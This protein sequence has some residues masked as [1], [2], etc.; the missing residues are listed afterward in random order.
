MERSFHFGPDVLLKGFAQ[1]QLPVLSLCSAI[2]SVV[3]CSL[4][5]DSVF[6]SNCFASES[7][8]L[9]KSSKTKCGPQIF[10]SE[11]KCFHQTHPHFS[12]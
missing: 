11:E 2:R 4:S 8:E 7:W 5:L 1:G 9:E 6:L 10:N 12:H 3:V